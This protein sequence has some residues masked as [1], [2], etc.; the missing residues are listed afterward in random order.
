MHKADT[1]NVREQSHGDVQKPKGIH[2]Y[3]AS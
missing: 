1:A 2:D 3:I